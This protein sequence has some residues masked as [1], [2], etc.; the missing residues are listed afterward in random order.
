MLGAIAG[1]IFDTLEETLAEARRSAAVT[2]D[3]PE[4]IKGAQA[5]AAAIFLART[6]STKEEIRREITD[7]FG[8]DLDR[9][10]ADIRPH[11][12]F[13]VTCQGSV[14]EALT[15]FL[16]ADDFEHTIRLAISLGGDADTQGAIAGAVAEAF[17]DGIPED[18][19]TEVDRL[20]PSD[21]AEAVATFRSRH[22]IR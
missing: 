10:I 1:D 8:Y 2:H 13:D 17:W 19:E 9:T 6:G 5:T 3:H 4:G 22:R 15:A 20:L 18:I 12:S 16:G 14:P 21:M 7:R 11:Y